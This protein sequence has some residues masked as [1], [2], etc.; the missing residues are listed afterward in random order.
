MTFG[1]AWRGVSGLTNR[2]DIVEFVR[3][4]EA[5]AT[6]VI[7]VTT[8][9]LR[10]LIDDELLMEVASPA[11][12]D[13]VSIVTGQTMHIRFESVSTSIARACTLDNV[14]AVLGFIIVW[15]TIVLFPVRD[16]DPS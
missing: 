8:E 9:D 15:P 1:H 6:P 13:R 4:A 16:L 3:V 7:E 2:I 11:K 14:N 12:V 5:E 10:R